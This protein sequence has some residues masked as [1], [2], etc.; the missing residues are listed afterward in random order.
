MFRTCLPMNII[1]QYTIYTCITKFRLS[2]SKNILTVQ[3]TFAIILSLTV[4]KL[5]WSL[6]VKRSTSL[7]H[8]Q[9]NKFVMGMCSLMMTQPS[10]TSAKVQSQIINPSSITKQSMRYNIINLPLVIGSL[11][12]EYG[13]RPSF[14]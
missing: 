5:N 11:P 3:L 9:E 8:R 1:W 13:V 14:L 2:Q 6:A 10:G 4:E 7:N 12:S